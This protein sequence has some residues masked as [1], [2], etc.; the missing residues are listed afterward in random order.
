MSEPTYLNFDI[1]IL[2]RGDGYRA[3]VVASPVD[4]G[5]CAEF[6]L[7]PD[8][9]RPGGWTGL[10]DV[11][12]YGARLFQ[13]LFAGEV[14]THLRLSQ[15]E[16]DR[17]GADGLRI[18]LI[19]TD[20]P[21]LADVPWEFLYDRRRDQ[22]LSLSTRTPI[23][24]Y[25]DLSERVKPLA[26][27]PPLRVLVMLS[28]PKDRAQLDVD[29]EWSRLSHALADLQAMGR[30][31]L[32]LLEEPTLPALQDRLREKE[33]HVFH[34][35]G[36]GDFDGN[37]QDGLLILENE[38]GMSQPVR[39]EVLGALL[40]NEPTLQLALLNACEA[41]KGSQMDPFAGV[42]Q[43]LVRRQIPAVIAMQTVITDTAAKIFAH[44]FYRALADGYPVDKALT[45]ARVAIFLQD[46]QY[47]WAIPVLFMRAADGRLEADAPVVVQ[48]A[49]TVIGAAPRA[50]VRR[51]VEIGPVAL[52]LVPLVAV[53]VLV[54]ALLS[55]LGLLF[56]GPAQ[57]DGRFNVAVAQ[58][59]VLADGGRMGSSTESELLTGWIVDELEA[60]NAA[61]AEAQISL[62]HDGLPLTE[63]RTRLGMVGGVT[64]GDRAAAAAELAHAV[65]A[66]VV[67]Y[68]HVTGEDPQQFVLEFYVA[69]GLRVESAAV[70]GRYRLGDPISI[71]AGL[72]GDPVVRE[73]VARR[74]RERV[75]LAVWMM[76]ALRE[77]LLGSP[78]QVLALLR[79]ADRELTALREQGDGKEHLYYLKGRAALFLD[80]YDEAQEALD[81]A[82]RSDP[83]YA[84]AQIAL[85]SVYLDRAQTGQTPEE[86]LA[87]PG[88]LER[89]IAAYRDG[90]RLAREANEPLT[91]VVAHLALAGA[92]RVQAETYKSVAPPD[93]GQAAQL[94]EQA[95][96]EL[97]LV[98][99][100]LG[101]EE[102]YR[103]LAQA[104]ATLGATYVQHGQLLETERDVP[105]ARA[106]YQAAGE[107]YAG[108][109][110]QADRAPA[111]ELLRSEVVDH[112]EYGCRRWAALAGE[113][114]QKLDGD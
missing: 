82:L 69:P 21:E 43:S 114:A 56:V 1:E 104:Y 38:E 94:F 111:D 74:V 36:H 31:E 27:A 112:E 10:D 9:L 99:E 41:G 51:T 28:N 54:V 109:I 72:T 73:S 25:L 87:D 52:P 17:T 110:A 23:V 76:L 24:R 6:K 14:Y 102:Q 35:V 4:R 58:V 108:C 45:E 66:D 61:T 18:R 63:K 48:P 78:A 84:R 103:L 97:Q 39:G 65:R 60:A 113:Y 68:G 40:H 13:Y 22:F 16:A 59:G 101:R 107:A 67:I 62:W 11:K 53:P 19:L 49:G 85:G 96:D 37:A 100:P 92:Y 44:E 83:G 93:N 20:V 95:I 46:N 91:E 7:A 106:R 55:I 42:A 34:Y 8:E 47:E 80:F 30:V 88:D 77:D 71:P 105:G 15:D 89:A 2:R 33:Y 79:Q 50:R 70:L 90:L 32:D 98:I 5:C 29:E 86:R 64:A 3:Q 75:E 12:E 57:M 26:V 81:R